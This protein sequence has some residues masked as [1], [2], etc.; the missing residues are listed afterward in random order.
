VTIRPLEPS[1]SIPELTLLVRSAYQRL[2]DLGL[3]FWGTWQSEEDTRERCAE[4]HCLVA[5][6]GGTIVGTVTVRDP[7]EDGDPDWYRRPDVWVAGQLAVSP[8]RQ[9]AGIGSLL[10]GEAERHAFMNGATEIAIDTAESAT[11]LIDYYARRGYRKVGAV[12]WEG[13]NYVSVV[14]S[15]RLRPV[16]ETE[17][18]VM[19][20]LTAD[21]MPAILSHWEDAR[22]K[23]L[24]PPG[25][26]TPEHC[27]EIFVPEIE[28]LGKFPRSGHHWGVHL[29]GQP[30]GTM[31]LSLERSATGSIGYGFGAE[32]WGKGYATEVVREVSRYAFEECG[33][34]R[35]QAFVYSPNEASKRVLLKCGFVREGALREKIAWGDGRVDDEIF[36]LLQREWIS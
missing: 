22:F 26:I 29:D 8:A 9:N 18:L 12:D 1:D 30:I 15:K 14:M 28:R 35:L 21:D 2:A 20:D 10:M 36:G 33:L 19:R 24:F 23:S 34:H 32:H 25:R 17:R 13:T 7:R 6:E 16:L 4:G 31:R 5:D 11:H 27:R 3:R